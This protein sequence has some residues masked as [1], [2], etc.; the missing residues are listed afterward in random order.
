[1]YIKI[2]NLKVRNNLHEMTQ[3]FHSSAC[4]TLFKTSKACSNFLR[5]FKV[6]K[7]NMKLKNKKHVYDVSLTRQLSR[8]LIP[9]RRVSDVGVL[10]QV[11][12]G[13]QVQA[14]VAVIGYGGNFPEDPG[15]GQ[16]ELL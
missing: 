14:G 6:P 8:N 12:H 4:R 2:Q 5:F 15:S 13:L 10:Q 7:R 9:V 11:G 1:M 3:Y 16:A